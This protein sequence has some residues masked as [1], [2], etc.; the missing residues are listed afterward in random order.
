MSS[1]TSAMFEARA[2]LRVTKWT[3]NIR[4][5]PLSAAPLL[6]RRAGAVV[7]FNDPNVVP[8]KTT[9]LVPVLRNDHRFITLNR[10]ITSR[11]HLRIT[12]ISPWLSRSPARA[13]L[14]ASES[15]MPAG[16]M[17]TAAG[18]L[19]QRLNPEQRFAHLARQ[20]RRRTY[21]APPERQNPMF[22]HVDS[23][24]HALGVDVGEA[25]SQISTIS[26]AHIEKH[27]RLTVRFIS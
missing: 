18:H 11:G 14:L 24:A 19:A 1:A 17:Q 4:G 25:L 23:V 20:R 13:P 15:L 26:S 3:N 8:H 16:Y 12:G 7:R 21:N 10:L 6:E 9:E 27:M 5:S 2:N 22:R